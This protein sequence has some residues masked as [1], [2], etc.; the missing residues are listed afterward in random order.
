[1]TPEFTVLTILS[2]C[3]TCVLLAGLYVIVDLFHD[4]ID[5]VEQARQDDMKE[6]R[7]ERFELME[8]IQRPQF[9]PVAPTNDKPEPDNGFNDNLHLVGTMDF[10]PDPPDDAA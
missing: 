9:T 3:F 8:R 1:M 7:R 6:W 2:V 4:H 5:I 10:T